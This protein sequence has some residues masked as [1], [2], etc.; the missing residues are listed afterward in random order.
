MDIPYCIDID[1][2]GIGG[3][4]GFCMETWHYCREFY[5]DLDLYGKSIRINKISRCGLLNVD[6]SALR[7]LYDANNDPGLITFTGMKPSAFNKCLR[8]FAPYFD[9]YSPLSSNLKVS[10]KNSPQGHKH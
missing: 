5:L 9:S 6:K 8:L 7:Y 4:A 1:P 3:K 10:I 2:I